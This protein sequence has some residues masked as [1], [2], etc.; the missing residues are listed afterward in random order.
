MQ[1]L[2]VVSKAEFFKYLVANATTLFDFLF[3]RFV[4]RREHFT[5][6]YFAWGLHGDVHVRWFGNLLLLELH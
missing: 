5:Y 4:M 1:V 3:H 6:S 2:F